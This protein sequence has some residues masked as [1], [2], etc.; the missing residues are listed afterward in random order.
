M[1]GKLGVPGREL[2]R[3]DVGWGFVWE[4][5]CRGHD[6]VLCVGWGYE[7]RVEGEDVGFVLGAV[8]SCDL[9]G[10]T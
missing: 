6:L 3:E 1:C 2:E 10:N 7:G 9:T 4:M 5:G 8:V